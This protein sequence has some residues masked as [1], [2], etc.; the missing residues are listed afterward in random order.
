MLT[1][2]LQKLML[3]GSVPASPEDSRPLYQDRE[4]AIS[5]NTVWRKSRIEHSSR[6][7]SATYAYEK[8]EEIET[9]SRKPPDNFRQLKKN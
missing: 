9:S 4:N 3:P 1:S 8:P 6:S 5:V 2:Y 7:P